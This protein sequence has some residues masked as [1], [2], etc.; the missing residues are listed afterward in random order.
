MR[1]LGRHA[2]LLRMCRQCDEMRSQTCA[3]SPRSRGRAV[4]T[5]FGWERPT[6][7]R[8]GGGCVPQLGARVMC[9]P[10]GA[11]TARGGVKDDAHRAA[12]R[13][14]TV[15]CF[16]RCLFRT[17]VFAVPP[18]TVFRVNLG[19][20]PLF[21][22]LSTCST[23]LGRLHALSTPRREPQASGVHINSVTQLICTQNPPLNATQAS[24][25]TP[26]D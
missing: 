25:L 23:F 26:S 12:L 5:G 8:R 17:G 13:A 14:R 3:R 9:E 4:S 15:K 16:E 18:Y 19:F 22:V 6:P 1:T 10:H 11:S 2:P 7:W 21:H 24:I 20:G